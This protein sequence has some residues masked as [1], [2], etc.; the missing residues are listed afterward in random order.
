MCCQCKKEGRNKEMFTPCM[1]TFLLLLLFFLMIS[2]RNFLHRA[3]LLKD[4][5]YR[6][7]FS[8]KEETKVFKKK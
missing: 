6:Y 7:T 5:M 2:I 8:F 3:D 4:H 1:V